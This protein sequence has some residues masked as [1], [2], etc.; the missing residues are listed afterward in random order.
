[1]MA[2]EH[3]YLIFDDDQGAVRLQAYQKLMAMYNVR[4]H[5]GAGF[6]LGIFEMY[7]QEYLALGGVTKQLEMEIDEIIKSTEYAL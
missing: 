2:L 4:C 5:N 3:P 1:M 6:S 7:K